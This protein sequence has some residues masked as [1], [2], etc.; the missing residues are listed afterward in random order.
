MIALN[1]RCGRSANETAP[2][3]EQETAFLKD[4]KSW[5]RTAVPIGVATDIDQILRWY[6][7]IE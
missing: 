2:F 6:G 3:T 5:F 4:I 1:S 7:W